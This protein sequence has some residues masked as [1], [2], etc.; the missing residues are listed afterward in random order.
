MKTERLERAFREEAAR[1]LQAVRQTLERDGA[2]DDEGLTEVFRRLH[3]VKGMAASIGRSALA[4][5]A[6]RLEERVER[7]RAERGGL[8]AEDRAELAAGSRDLA[9]RLGEAA[10]VPQPSAA[11]DRLPPARVP[12]ERLDRL[13][14][15]ALGLS[16][17]QQ[18]LEHR[19]GLPSDGELLAL[20]DG[21]SAAVRDLRREIMELRLLPVRSL[22][23][24]LEGAV[25]RWSQERG[26]RVQVS[27]RGD[28]VRADRRMLERLLDPLGHLLRNAIVH[29]IEPAA[30]REQQGKPVVGT[31]RVTAR[32]EQ[33]LLL[34]QVSDDGRGVDPEEVL[35]RA[36]ERGLIAGPS[37][38]G[39]SA[40]AALDLLTREGMS[41]LDAADGLAGRGVGLSAARA[42]IERLGGSLRLRRR[43]GPGLTAEVRVPLGLAVL[44]AFL[45]QTR[46]RTFAVPVGAVRE[47]HREDGSE[48]PRGSP[49]ERVLDLAEGLGLDG[50]EGGSGAAARC[51]LVVET[52]G[53][54]AAL[55]VERVLSRAEVVVRPL[56][57]PLESVPPWTGAALLPWGGLAL[58]LDP[59]R[60]TPTARAIPADAASATMAE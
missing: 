50:R 24:L 37:P 7:A 19:L 34:L 43:S 35:Q 57:P 56:G 45:V 33:D 54:P 27:L 11:E 15:L 3:S 10:P 25:R 47:V 60:V 5:Q 39:L 48:G 12:D 30:E 22:L 36:A 4:E 51:L 52:A 28:G 55:A 32:R 26:V 6:H 42:E 8:T 21:I 40:E 18:R 17:A 13:F 46:G 14:D 16:T 9:A 59:L 20:R 29:G 53:A 23:P 2:V 49:P 1:H 31:V 44:D 41:R 58:V 38:R